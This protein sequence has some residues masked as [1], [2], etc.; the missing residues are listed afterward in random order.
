MR[1]RANLPVVPQEELSNRIVT[2]PVVILAD[3]HTQRAVQEYC[4]SL[5]RM[6][7]S[8]RQ[9]APIAWT[10][11]ALP[12]AARSVEGTRGEELRSQVLWWLNQCWPWPLDAYR[13]YLKHDTGVLDILA[14]GRS[15]CIRAVDMEGERSR[16]GTVRELPDGYDLTQDYKSVNVGLADAVQRWTQFSQG[17]GVCVVLCGTTHALD[18]IDG[19]APRLRALGHNVLVLLPC[20]A[21]WELAIR[22]VL[23]SLVDQR[24][25][26]F[27]GYVRVPVIHDGNYSFD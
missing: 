21:E 16:N 11:E 13:D 4:C 22:E 18:T 17:R 24:L 26:V 8:R 5:V 23:P 14:G 19:P 9:A 15:V 25:E 6:L 2:T 27:P 12:Q 1:D 7:L 20:V 10:L 3:C